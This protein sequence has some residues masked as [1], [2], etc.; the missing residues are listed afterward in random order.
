MTPFATSQEAEDH[1]IAQ[2]YYMLAG[3]W[4]RLEKRAAIKIVD[5][6]FVIE[7]KPDV[8]V[9]PLNMREQI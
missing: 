7:R 8:V 5:R 2:G 4:C 6:L 3:T 9:A 1:L